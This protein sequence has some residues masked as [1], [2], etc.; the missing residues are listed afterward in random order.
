MTHVL[1]RQLMEPPPLAVSGHGM[2]LHTN[3]GKEY[4]DATSGGAAVSCLGYGHPGVADAISDQLSRLAFIHGSFFSS[5]PA[6]A[7]AEM[8]LQDAPPGMA[9]VLFSSGGSESNEAALKLVRQAWLEQGKPS[10]S[11]IIARRQSYHGASVG[12]LSISGN[13]GRR[14]TYT[15]YLFDA[16]FIEPCYAYRLQHQN[17]DDA[18]YGVRA[19]NELEAAI[20]ELGPENVAAFFAEPVVGATL[21]CAPAA[22]GYLKRIR[23]ICD[24]YD[25]LLVFD[26]IM[27]G[28]GRTGYSYACN[29]D[30]VAPDILTIAKG[31]GG[32]FQPMGATLINNRILDALT[33]GSRILQH[34]FTYMGHPVSCAAALAVQQIIVAE[35]LLDN[36]RVQGEF[37]QNH[38]KECLGDH[39]HVGDIRGRGLFVGIEM[40]HNKTDKTPFDPSL[41]IHANIKTAALKHGL[42]VYPGGGTID[43]TFGDHVLLSPAYIAGS[44]DIQEIVRRL[45]LALDTALTTPNKA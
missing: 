8:L 4:L 23:Q 2:W 5:E 20:L 11:R 17:E 18:E 31:L 42:M 43:G 7:L 26:E 34:G 13:L 39:P 41:K 3:D 36:V 16:H 37:L 29:E 6:E 21:G 24:Q 40:V 30:D 19:A 45:G 25:V 14:K 27:C 33:G 35:N 15:P 1:H 32:G 28:T 22:P 38:L 12:A 9:R 10:K 44:D